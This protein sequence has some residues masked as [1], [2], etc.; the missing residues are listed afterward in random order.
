[1]SRASSRTTGSPNAV[2]GA[3]YVAVPTSGTLEFWSDC[4]GTTGGNNGLYDYK[5]ARGG[6]DCYGSMQLHIG[7]N[8]VFAWNRWSN[9]VQAAGT[10]IGF[11][12]QVG[13]SGQPDWTFATNAGTYAKRRL[14]VFVKPAYC[15]S[16]NEGGNATITCPAGLTVDAINYASY[17]TPTGVC[18]AFV[19]GGCNA[20]TSTAVLQ[21]ACVGQNTCTVAAT[22]AVF[23][24]PCG[25]T[26]KRLYVQAT[27][28]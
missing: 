5:D 25:G 1:M 15:A 16:P 13:G 8:T 9:G 27:C 21:A 23:G 26:G 20:A 19:T 11:G 3:M 17:G 12:N 22:N 10:D 2:S 14:E 18:G 28:K 7:T 24:D 6:T 4:Y